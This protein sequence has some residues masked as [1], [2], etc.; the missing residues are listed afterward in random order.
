MKRPITHNKKWT[1]ELTKKESLKYKNRNQF[2]NNNMGAYLSSYR[3][4]WLD[5]FFPK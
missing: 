4:G 3:N 1:Y 2:R 5:E